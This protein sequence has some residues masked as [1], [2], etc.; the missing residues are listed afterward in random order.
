M[1]EEEFDISWFN[2]VEDSTTSP[3]TGIKINID[4]DNSTYKEYILTP[5]FNKETYN[6]EISLM[7]NLDKVDI[8]QF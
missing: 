2:L 6:Y 8:Q 5:T 7:E 3:K 4:T 1:T